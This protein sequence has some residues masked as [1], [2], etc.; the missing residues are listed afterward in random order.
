MLHDIDESAFDQAR[1][2]MADG[3]TGAVGI[4]VGLS[5]VNGV[6][7][8]TLQGTPPL[9]SVTLDGAVFAYGV[10]EP[11][12]DDRKYLYT[13]EDVERYVGLHTQSQNRII[14]NDSATRR[15]PEQAPVVTALPD[16][17]QMARDRLS[18]MATFGSPD[19]SAVR[20]A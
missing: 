1:A 16:Q 20:V 15:P 4:G 8:P 5:I 14:V 3:M 7:T 9:A 19:G 11:M 2:R 13:R 12:R 10:G 6:V 18:L 17:N